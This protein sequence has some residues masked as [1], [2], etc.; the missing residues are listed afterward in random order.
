MIKPYKYQE[1][2]IN[3]LREA[4]RVHRIVL[5]YAP[6]GAGK[7]K[8]SQFI[9]E[10]LIKN[11]KHVLFTTPRIK[12]ATQ[13]QNSF[14]FGNL[15]LGSKTKDNGSL[16]TIASVQSLYSRKI[17]QHFDYIFIDECHFAHGSKYLDYIFNT[18]PN[19]KIIGLSATPI[20]ENGYLLQGYESI[21]KEVTVK[22]LIELG[23][24]TDV[25]VYTSKNQ[26]DFSKVDIV[27]GDYNQTQTT[28]ILQEEQ[29][30]SNAIQ[31]WLRLASD[32]KT[33]V[34]A[35]D[36]EHAEKLK[37]E[38]TNLNYNVSIVH[39]KLSEKQ[40]EKEYKDFNINNTTILINVDMATFGFDEP[41]IECMLFVRCI[42]SLRLYKQM[43]GR[44][45]RKFKGKKSC[46]MIDC[47]NVVL[48]NGYP[49]D[50]IPFIKKAVINKTVD[51]LINVER[52]VD[53]SINTE[54]ISKERVEYLEK[55]GSLID[56][57][58]S[59]VYQKE[60]DLVDDCK[61]LLK[62]A[63]FYTWRQNSGK[64]FMSGR[65][66]HFTDKNGLPDMTL[67]YKSVYI[68]LELKLPSGRLTKHQKE[69]LPEFI[70]NKIHFFII[71]NIIDLFEA[72]EV[73]QINIIDTKQGVLIKNELFNLNEN[74]KKYRK[75]YKLLA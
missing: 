1:K 7:T 4:L 43:V 71:E 15:I 29:V 41:S 74:Q 13:T 28:K 67:I 22:E 9:I 33:I 52:N 49:T 57:Y 5:V 38:F 47:A 36:I 42:K 34:F 32:K 56:L 68:G 45:I 59:K 24:L 55:I 26:P 17:T 48:D 25:E 3:S 66:V 65:W 61:K 18:Y 69:T 50:E 6:T 53:G 37:Q 51:K 19:A 44:G 27:N 11:N 73:V 39:S 64:A 60:Q 35:T 46:L 70:D 54:K 14:G 16:C 63:G 62:R 31:E 40:I 58:S 20:D 30:I 12:L 21:I 8:I 23:Y 2:I 75:K 10:R 72:L